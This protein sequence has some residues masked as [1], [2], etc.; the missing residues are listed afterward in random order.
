MIIKRDTRCTRSHTLQSLSHKYKGNLENC[1]TYV[2]LTGLV[3]ILVK[4]IFGCLKQ[5]GRL[6]RLLRLIV[7]EITKSL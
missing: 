6:A 3:K 5:G 1:E 2:Q 4:K 7:G